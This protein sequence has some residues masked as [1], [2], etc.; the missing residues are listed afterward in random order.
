MGKS[1]L[2]HTMKQHVLGLMKQGDVDEPVIEWRCSPHYQNTGFHPAID[3]YERALRFRPEEPPQDRIDRMLQ[4]LEQYGLVRPETAPLWA[5][6]LSLP[7]P[8]RF[9]PLS[10]S[11]VR[12]REETFR[13]MLEWLHTRAARKPI[14]FIVEDLHWVDASTLEFLGQFLAEGLH[15][16]ILT[17]LTFRPEFKT[18][19][20]AV[21][22]QTSLALNRLTRRQV[23]DL[24][25]NKVKRVLPDAV[26]QQVYAR[27]GGV[28]LF[29]EEFTRMVQ[30]SGMEDHEGGRGAMV[31]GHAIPATLQ[32]LMMSRLDRMEGEREV[33][34]LASVL[35][36]EVAYEV[37]AAITTLD[38]PTLQI[39]LAKLVQEEIL[40]PKGRPPRCSYIFK[41]ALLE[42][43]LYNTLV[44]AKRQQFHRQIAEVLEAQF[45]QTTDKRP[46]L[47]AHHFSEGGLAEASVA[48]WL[49]AGLRGLERSANVEAIGHLT[50]GLSI[51]R[52]LP[53]SPERDAQELQFL[54]PLGTSYMAAR[55]YAAPEVEPVFRRA[56]ELCER[57]GDPIQQVAIMRGVA[58]WHLM[59]CDFKVCTDFA[60]YAME[61]AEEFNAPEF[62][63]VALTFL[64]VVALYRGDFTGARQYSARAVSEYDD[65]ER[66]HIWPSSTGEDCGL[67]CRNY[68]ALSLWHS[69]YPDQ[70]L[71]LSRL[72]IALARTIGHPFSLAYALSHAGSLLESCQLG[73]EAQ[74]A[75]EE[76]IT[77][78]TE[79]GFAL[80]H[81][82]GTLCRGGGLVSQANLDGL[83]LLV[84]GIERYRA[85]GAELGL[86]EYLRQLGDAYTRAGQF[87]QALTAINDGLSFAQKNDE[88]FQEAELHRLRGELHLAE[89]DDHSAA[90]AC[91]HTAIETAR[92]QQSRAWELRATTSLAR[93]WQRQ[94]RAGEARDALAA[95]YESYTEGFT[96]P[97][98]VDARALLEGRATERAPTRARGGPVDA[99]P[100]SEAQPRIEDPR[101]DQ[102]VE[103]PRVGERGE[104]ARFAERVES[105]LLGESAAVSAL[106]AAISREAAGRGLLLLTGP[107]GAGHEAVARA[108]HDASGRS[109]P[110]ISV[111]C[112]EFRTEPRAT[113]ARGASPD[114]R[115]ATRLAEA[116]GGTLFL[117]AVHEL[118]S[119]LR[120]ALQ[121]WL[122][123]E[124][125]A[126]DVRVIASTTRDLVRDAQSGAL[127]PV[128]GMLLHNR[129]TIPALVDR[130]EDIP[131]LVDHYVRIHAQQQGK[132]VD[133]VSSASL[134]RLEAHVW[135]GNLRE[136]CDVLERAVLR[137][138]SPVLDIDDAL[139]E[140]SVAVGNYRLIELLGAGGM[141]EVWL[142][143]H[144]LLARPAAVKLVRHDAQGG[145]AQEELAH[146][147]QREARVTA[148]LRSPHTVQLYDFGV[149]ERGS[150]YYVMELLVGL[151]LHRIVSRFGPQPAERVIMLLRQACRSL[152]DAHGHGLVHRDIK[153]AN[154]FVTQLGWEYDYLKVLD[155]GMVTDRPGQNA[156]V[157]SSQGIVRGT[158]AFMAP[159]QV[160]GD[161]RLDGRADLYSLA[162]TAYWA[163]TGRLPFEA[164]T[165]MQMLLHHAQTAPLPPSQ[166]SE[167]PIPR[168]L[169]ILLMKCLSKRPA[170]RSASALD[171]DAE[172]ARVR[173]EQPWTDDRARE[174]WATHAPDI[175]AAHQQVRDEQ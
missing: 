132:P 153:P 108:L 46:E 82:T 64:G 51:V 67:P 59:H 98:L 155:F 76:Q 169:E 53:E 138:R 66:T 4:G 9:P 165:P 95:V 10:L 49:K 43:A 20:P 149:S 80:W 15:D 166:V 75:G 109:G 122:A 174:W 154:L 52:A 47:V 171:F 137:A 61:L 107:P 84:E 100:R 81:A 65:P 160:L 44:T 110:F 74:A 146:R 92:R 114:L 136:L 63:M 135:P 18:P 60:A 148:G 70:A 117:D 83:P 170:E 96:T 129:I 145:A 71:Q 103:G 128:M 48:Y 42:D 131:L 23:G 125:M 130:R 56:S 157:L 13:A 6:L 37:L 90:E 7:T 168:P 35:G 89:S 104:G 58:G 8:D 143:R 36:R 139:L 2:V 29:V 91:F 28:P 21:A 118:P 50:K 140:E 175:M 99:E 144:R 156:T 69:G 152:A 27:A 24:M 3:Y 55:G 79:Q 162:C 40:Y 86:S 158:P 123:R 26:V 147:F 16:S 85:S 19:W 94:A 133:G 88:R 167:L 119:Q 38:E 142:A 134:T 25:T 33:A 161:S 57:L 120:P 22:H 32:D 124:S 77:I 111:S 126:P 87:Q 41:H 45:P 115:L 62:M 105:A 12:Q 112:P 150:F 141:G 97:D 1:R 159:E 172:L 34:Q 173:C 163:L 164:G 11:P 5:S 113:L 39:E 93:L 78:A 127:D 72:T 14:L 68:L 101:V 73:E 151:D 102:R 17:L 30:E 106:R 116:A 121:R 54:N 31:P